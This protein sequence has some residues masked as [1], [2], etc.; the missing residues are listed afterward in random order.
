M[1][2]NSLY[3]LFILTILFFQKL[4]GQEFKEIEF[5]VYD[6]SN[7]L[8]VSPFSGG[9]KCPQLSETDFNNDGIKDIYVFDRVGN[10]HGAY[11]GQKQNS[12]KIEY[13]FKPEYVASFPVAES[14]V[15]L[16]DYDKDGISDFFAYSDIPGIDGI[17]VWKGFYDKNNLLYFKRLNFKAPYNILFFPL[18]AGG[19]S[20]LYVTRIDIPSL[21]DIDCDGDL[22]I[23]TFNLNG[24]Y[25][26]FYRN[27]SVEKNFGNDSLLF[28]LESQCWGGFYESG[29]SA[30]IDLA[31]D[32]GTCF[33]TPPIVLAGLNI[34]SGSTLL[35]LDIDNDGDKDLLLG[36]ISF[37]N[38]TLL[39]NGGNCKT[40]WMNKQD[41]YFPSDDFPVDLPTFP[42]S[43]SLDIN[44]DGLKDLVFSTNSRNNSADDSPV[45]LY[46]NKGN[47]QKSEFKLEKKNFLVE[48]SI[49]IGSGAFPAWVDIN[50][51]GLLDLIVGNQSN[52]I[53]QSN[54]VASL[55]YYENIGTKSKPAFKIRDNNFLDL[56]KFISSTFGGYRPT[57]GDLDGDG[58][59]DI[60]VG[61]G[62]GPLLFGENTPTADKT[63]NVE[64]FIFP[65]MDLKIGLNSTPFLF[66]VNKDGL[67]D[68]IIGDIS[69]S[70]SYFQN[71]GTK[72]KPVFNPE[73]NKSPNISRWG[74]VNTTSPGY[75]LGYSSPVLIQTKEGF[76]LIT[77]SDE[78]G[79]LPYD[80]GGLNSIFRQAEFQVRKN[81]IGARSVPAL[82]DINNDG[83]Y[84]LLV[85]N[86]RGG[87]QLYSTPWQSMTTAHKEIVD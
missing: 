52:Y 4:F 83:Y 79:I 64:T 20:N 27:E 3:A 84:E 40:A 7:N 28:R 5:P 87:L 51:D 6:K 16:R 35:T 39:S 65:Y 11:I 34:H 59:L 29:F 53:D 21:D 45:H 26:E 8:L 32:L 41:N 48:N 67:L 10:V 24:G 69:G 37:P 1:K 33:R 38:I 57:F 42:A 75:L 81:I 50:G 46:Y 9:L 73:S 49:D 86:A 70:I 25:A 12:G 22:D 72:T 47:N 54:I 2:T 77:G 62:R 74:S 43:F 66:D 23:V 82:A 60:I 78:K 15:L 36:D 68:L 63:F 58:D 61:T 30:K 17:Q 56:N 19:Q 44:Q 76:K 13:I 14:W 31:P 18:F 71:I 85:G 80:V 55:Y